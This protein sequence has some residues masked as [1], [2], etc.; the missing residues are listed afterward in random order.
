MGFLCGES[1]QR[2]SNQ[3]CAYG[4]EQLAVLCCPELGAGHTRAGI[5]RTMRAVVW[6]VF[7]VNR[8]P[9]VIRLIRI[10][11]MIGLLAGIGFACE[12]TVQ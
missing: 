2:Y 11:W 4:A 6:P 12:L 9:K 3:S 8:F 1:S 7:T 5:E 10:G